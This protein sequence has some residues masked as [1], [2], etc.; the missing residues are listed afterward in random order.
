MARPREQEE[1]A[2]L[3]SDDRAT[4]LGRRILDI[5]A[6]L[7]EEGD[8][9][10]ETVARNPAAGQGGLDDHRRRFAAIGSDVRAGLGEGARVTVVRHAVVV[11]VLIAHIAGAVAVKVRLVCVRRGRTIVGPRKD[12]A[13][14]IWIQR[15]V[16]YAVCIRIQV[17]RCASV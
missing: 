16:A 5:G 11:D 15:P 9:G 17:G 4:E 2:T 3:V 13:F 12:G 7:N 10:G 6:D 8:G 14:G 1:T